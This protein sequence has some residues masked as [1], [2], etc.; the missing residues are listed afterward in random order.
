MTEGLACAFSRM[1][2]L[3]MNNKT[4]KTLPP[5][6]HRPTVFARVPAGIASQSIR[7]K[8]AAS[9]APITPAV[10]I[11]K[12]MTEKKPLP[13]IQW[14]MSKKSDVASNPSGKTISM[15]WMG[16]PN[17]LTLLSIMYLLV[18]SPPGNGG[19]ETVVIFSL[20]LFHYIPLAFN[21]CKQ[22]VEGV[23][24][25]L[26]AFLLQL[27]GDLIVVDPNVL[28]GCEFR[29]RLLD[30]VL[31]GE[32]HPAMLA[33]VLDRLEWHGIHRVRTDQF[34]GVQHIAVGRIFRTGAGTQRS[35]HACATAPERLEAR[36]AEEALELLVDQARIGNGRFALEGLEPRLLD[37]IMRGLGLVFEQLVH[38]HIHAADK[39][40]GY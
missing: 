12:A 19:A 40:A 39:E 14:M 16:C 15:G 23:G 32:S 30:V 29:L 18:Q 31:N 34:L 6:C 20:L 1:G 3:T 17:A 26:H 7:P 13:V 22:L 11:Q 21:A 2:Q 9:S 37:G 27:P 38:E 28:E 25:P 33:E 4:M 8:I 35:L 36:R 10:I 24:E 5:P